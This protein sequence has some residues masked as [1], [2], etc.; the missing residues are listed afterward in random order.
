LTDLV[1][2][3][4]HYALMKGFGVK[5]FGELL[6]KAMQR[7]AEE[8]TKTS[9]APSSLGYT[10]S[11]PRYWYYAFN[12]TTFEYENDGPSI[13]NMDAGSDAGVRIANLLKKA[14][15]LVDD[16]VPVRLQDPPVFGF[17]DAMV[18][19]KGEVIPAEVKTTKNETWQYRATNNMVPGYQMLQLLIYM[20][21]TNNIRGFFITENKNTNQLYILPVV[22]T[23]ER[24][25]F[26]E[27]VFEWMRTVKKNAEEGE[28]PKRPFTKA[29]MQCKGCPVKKICW[30]GY[31]RGSVN[32]TD[33]NP[34][35]VD[36]PALEVPKTL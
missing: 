19:W 35:V 15:I 18:R 17:I 23:D 21:A 4:E 25:A 29:S 12:G 30:D 24:R 34:G 16:E 13:S 9:F 6:E 10:G 28:L 36:L 31:K 7:E 5:E 22:M 11:C 2:N 8:K 20:Y 27:Q 14:D 1:Y 33:P 3:N 26:V 32:G